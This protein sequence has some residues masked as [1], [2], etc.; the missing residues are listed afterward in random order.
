MAR[1]TIKT[2]PQKTGAK[3]N[4]SPVVDAQAGRQVRR[5][6]TGPNGAA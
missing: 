6:H 1:K 3:K 4:V 2:A 5:Q